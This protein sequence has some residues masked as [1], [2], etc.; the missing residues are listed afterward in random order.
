MI[1]LL[2]SEPD[3]NDTLLVTCPAFPEV[4]T[5]A[6][7]G[8]DANAH[9]W[10]NGLAAIEEAIA[11]RISD[12]EDIPPPAA[13][14]Q[15]KKHHGVW[16]KLPLMTGLKVQLYNALRDSDIENRAELARRLHWS[17]EQVDR[18]FR[19]DHNSRADQI[20]AAFRVL[21]RDIDVQIRETA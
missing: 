18:L 9:I 12:W 7:K 20:E 6:K 4:T 3:D 13:E 19:L 10:R 1:Y 11:A 14:A 8:R 21:N 5:F 15:I 17:R 2:Q 16:V